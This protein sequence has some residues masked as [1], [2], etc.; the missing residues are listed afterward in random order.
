MHL[1]PPRSSAEHLTRLQSRCQP[2]CVLIR[3]LAWERI[4]P[5]IT[6]VFGSFYF[7]VIVEL[8]TLVSYWL[9]VVGP[10]DSRDHPQFLQVIHNSCHMDFTNMATSSSQ[11]DKSVE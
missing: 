8:R 3:R 11:Q 5:K 4:P 2:Y 6:Q 7:L 1:L 9:M 10:S